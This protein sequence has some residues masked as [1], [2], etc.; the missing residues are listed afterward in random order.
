MSRILLVDFPLFL[1]GQKLVFLHKLLICRLTHSDMIFV[2]DIMVSATDI[3]NENGY[4]F[5][6]Q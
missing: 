5:G 2:L 4:C 1:W 3:K 6:R